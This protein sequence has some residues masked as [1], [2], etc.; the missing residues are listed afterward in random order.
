MAAHLDWEGIEREYRAGVKSLREIGATFGCTHT[1]IRKRALQDGWT[2]DLNAKIRAKAD[3]LV[4]KETVSRM[5]SAETR[6]A[7]RE[8]VEA[9][10][11]VQATIR[12]GHRADI[13]RTKR[14]ANALLERLEKRVDEAAR[15]ESEAKLD[16]LRDQA[17]TLKLLAETQ[18]TVIALEK[19]AFGIAPVV[20]AGEPEE[21]PAHIDPL[22]GARQIAFVLARAQALL[23][24]KDP[25][26][27]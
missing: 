27:A 2:R 26:A 20:Q 25:E 8:I 7:E 18:R 21:P 3:A 11:V 6:V 1:A 17:S 5:V 19:D 4:A 12:N 23:R 9:N 22:E 14:V 10:A 24:K 13:Q 16:D 15:A